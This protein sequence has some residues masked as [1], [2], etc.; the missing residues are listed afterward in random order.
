MATS[1][2]LDALSCCS[3]VCSTMSSQFDDV[4]ASGQASGIWKSSSNCDDSRLVLVSL[5]FEK[6]LLK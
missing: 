6:V 5:I 3:S 1:S 4:V 2:N